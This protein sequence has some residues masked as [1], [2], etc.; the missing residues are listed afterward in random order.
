MVGGCVV[1]LIILLLLLEM[2]AKSQTMLFSFEHLF[3]LVHI[4]VLKSF[5]SRVL[6]NSKLLHVFPAGPE[7]V[8]YSYET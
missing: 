5:S 1:L 6:S 8:A 3:V 2:E 4:D 7:D